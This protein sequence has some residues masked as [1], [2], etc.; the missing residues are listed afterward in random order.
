M[1]Y[2]NLVV[3]PEFKKHVTI[4]EFVIGNVSLLCFQICMAMSVGFHVFGCH[5][6]K[7]CQV[8]ISFI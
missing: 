6:E 4:M 2:D 3:L 7:I 1:L 5:S 8:F